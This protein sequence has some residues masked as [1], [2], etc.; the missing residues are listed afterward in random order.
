MSTVEQS[1]RALP[2]SADEVTF[3]V[4]LAQCVAEYVNGTRSQHAAF[5]WILSWQQAWSSNAGLPCNW[6]R[7]EPDE[8]FDDP[9]PMSSPR[10]DFRRAMQI[11][12]PRGA[13]RRTRTKGRL[14]VLEFAT[15]WRVREDKVEQLSMPRLDR[16]AACMAY[17]I[18][19]AL[20][21]LDDLGHCLKE[22]E[23]VVN[24]E[25]PPSSFDHWPHY[26]VNIPLTRRTCCT[27][28]HSAAHRQRLSRE[29][30]LN[31]ARKL[32]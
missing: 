19:S 11:L 15:V 10:R 31:N 7:W 16:P 12:R 28:K 17:V 14:S 32:K 5:H 25:A 29:R 30:K 22:C 9:S 6:A 26:F 27:D 24:P 3:R 21:N 4:T 13:S 18:G 2:S 20:L 1:P 23:F 8:T